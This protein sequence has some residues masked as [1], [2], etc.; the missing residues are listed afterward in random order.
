MG[1]DTDYVGNRQYWRPRLA[2]FP[3]AGGAAPAA[4]RTTQLPA[5][6]Y[7]GSPGTAGANALSRRFFDGVTASAPS[8]APLGG[9]SWSSVR[10]ATTIDGELWYGLTDGTFHRR[11][12]D[13]TT[14]GPDRL[15]DPYNDQKWSEVST[16]SGQTYRGLVPGF[17]GEISTTTGLAFQNGQLYSTQN[18][19]LHARGFTPDSGVVSGVRRQ[20]AAISGIAGI[21]FSGGDLWFS[22][23]AD[24]NLRKVAFVNGAPSGTPTVVSGPALGGVDWRSRTLFTGPGPDGGP[25][26]PPPANVAP[27]ASIAAP[28]CTGLSCTFD[29]RG[30]S[31]SDGTITSYAWSFG[32]NST[33]SGAT[34]SRTYS[35]GGT[36]QVTLT[37]TDNGGATASTTRSVTVS[38]STSGVSLTAVGTKVKGLQRVDLSWQGIAAAS[39]DVFRNGAKLATV[40]GSTYVDNI[41]VKGTGTYVYRVCAAGTTTCSANTTVVF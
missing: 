27:T 4:G 25:V 6:V 5:N 38:P 20:V 11:T 28:S 40:S 39:T 1:S 17:Y 15:V 35:A 37:V 23:T 18:G 8:S 9:M 30:S 16:G 13:G 22:S 41:G 29:G 32:D 7:L 34:T 19:V 14:Y 12:F 21:F 3:L 31:D 2:F 10:A 33:G 24:G 36:Y 26:N